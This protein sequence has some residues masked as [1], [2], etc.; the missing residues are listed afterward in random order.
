MQ[1]V[2]GRFL[3]YFS[4][5]HLCMWARFRPHGGP[6]GAR[7]R[8]RKPELDVVFYLPS[9]GSLL[10][11]TGPP[12]GG[13]AETQVYLIARELAC[14][15]CAVG[16]ICFPTERP[17]PEELHGIRIFRRPADQGDRRIVGA[18]LEALIVMKTIFQID[19]TV[20]VQRT[21]GFHTGL[22]ALAARL[23]RRKFVYSSASPV[24]FDL[25]AYGGSR[26]GRLLFRLGLAL[27][28]AI[29]VQTEEQVAMCRKQMGRDPV[30]I[31]S[32]SEVTAY[33]ATDRSLFL[34]IGRTHPSKRPLDFV[35][36]ASALPSAS[37][38][39]ILLRTGPWANEVA[40]SVGAAAA[41]VDNLTVS[42]GLP[43]AEVGRLID[44]AVA[45]VS[46]S[47]YEGMPNVF[48]EAWTRGVPVLSLNCDPDRVIQREGLGWFAHGSLDTLIDQGHSIWANRAEFASLAERCRSYIEHYHAP[49]VIGEH[50]ARIL[51]TYTG[52]PP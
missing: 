52:S 19:A 27:A 25:A 6:R 13:G 42:D 43:R 23:C 1:V 46:T 50:W 37:F 14:R 18:V 32:L 28:Q 8:G 34:W 45:V 16:L 36:F 35:A 41:A 15:G 20:Y 39:M 10:F 12:T 24:D 48:L 33:C 40:T 44:H 29:V 5:L 26:R 2:A 21:G 49:V 51:S 30:L 4:G 11:D 47:D 22:V 3:R 38:R 31:R 17:L 7:R 9:V